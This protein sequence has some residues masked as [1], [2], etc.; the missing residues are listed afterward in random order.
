MSNSIICYLKRGKD[1]LS[2]KEKSFTV[3]QAITELTLSHLHNFIS[4]LPLL[5]TSLHA[6]SN[7]TATFGLLL[8]SWNPFHYFTHM[9]NLSIT[10]LS[11][12]I[13]PRCSR[14]CSSFLTSCYVHIQC[15][16]CDL[17][18]PLVCLVMVLYMIIAVKTW[19]EQDLVVN[20]VDR[21]Y[22]LQLVPL[23]V[24]CVL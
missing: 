20:S 9:Q 13:H 5:A 14:K 7:T 10:F 16:W 19:V 15:L 2:V 22:A 24:F 12:A 8:I 6:W 21:M 11:S 18:C 17:M 1:R 4:T 3:A 23:I